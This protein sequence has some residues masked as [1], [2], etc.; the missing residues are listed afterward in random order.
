MTAR[1]AAERAVVEAEEGWMEAEMEA[2]PVGA[3]VEAMAEVAMAKEEEGM[4]MVAQAAAESTAVLVEAEAEAEV[5]ARAE[6]ATVKEE[7]G[8]EKV[9]QVAK[10]GLQEVDTTVDWAGV[11]MAKAEAERAEVEAEEGE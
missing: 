9:A 11:V 10:V 1:A 5:V 3:V 4:A 2:A 6:A 8:K 7:G